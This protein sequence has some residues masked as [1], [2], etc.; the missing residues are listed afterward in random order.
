MFPV[1][2]GLLFLN[3]IVKLFGKDIDVPAR[4][5]VSAMVAVT[6]MRPIGFF[7][8]LLELAPTRTRQPAT[9]ATC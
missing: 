2:M 7:G 4:L 1:L 6:C 9:A 5:I 8:R 3:G